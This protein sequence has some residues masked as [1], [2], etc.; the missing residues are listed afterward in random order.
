MRCVDG[1]QNSSAGRSSGRDAGSRQVCC[2]ELGRWRWAAVIAGGLEL[3]L[4]AKCLVP[5]QKTLGG[6]AWHLVSKQADGGDGRGLTVLT[7]KPRTTAQ[8]C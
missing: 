4:D 3:F 1:R 7:I 6:H 5:V 8:W 2:M